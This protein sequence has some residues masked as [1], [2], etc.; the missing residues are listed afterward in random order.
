MI[1]IKLE[2]SRAKEIESNRRCKARGIE[3]AQLRKE[4]QAND[5]TVRAL[6]VKLTESQKEKDK[7][8]YQ[9]RKKPWYP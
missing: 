1:R 9:A 5:S 4:K 6:G 3:V 8:R 7:W 2:A